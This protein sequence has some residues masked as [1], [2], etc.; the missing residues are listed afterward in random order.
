MSISSSLR[1][2]AGSLLGALRTRVELF[3]IEWQQARAQI[4]ALVGLLLA[5]VAFLWLAA[6]MFSFMLVTLAWP[7]P[8]RNWVVV[9]LLLFYLLAGIGSLLALK[10]RLENPDNHPFAATMQEL[11]RD[12]DMLSQVLDPESGQDPTP[13]GSPTGQGNQR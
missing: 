3:S 6:M 13:K 1:L 4:A 7:T 10:R 5:A 8:Y 9:G 2:L 12:A 11:S